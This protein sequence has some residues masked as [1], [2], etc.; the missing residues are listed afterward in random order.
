L[1]GLVE[2]LKSKSTDEFVLLGSD[3]RPFGKR[4]DAI[5]KRFCKLKTKLGFGPQQVFH[6]IRKTVG[7]QLE[8]AGVSE[9]TIAD[10]VGRDRPRI[11]YGLYSAGASLK[12]KA[13]ALELVSYEDGLANPRAA[14]RPVR[15]AKHD[16]AITSTES[17]FQ[18]IAAAATVASTSAADA[19]TSSAA[20]WAVTARA[21]SS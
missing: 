6:S 2:R 20:K 17:D 11:T 4:S 15:H 16:T 18:S 19:N 9:N 14:K 8:Q 10:L 13:E 3:E 21:S 1:S 12:Q 5:G 7:S